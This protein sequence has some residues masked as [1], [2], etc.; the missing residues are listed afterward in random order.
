MAEVRTGRMVDTARRRQRHH[1][2]REHKKTSPGRNNY[3]K[4]ATRREPST[5][6]RH[7]LQ[8]HN[9]TSS[10][11]IGESPIPR[12]PVVLHSAPIERVILQ[13]D[14]SKIQLDRVG[15]RVMVRVEATTSNSI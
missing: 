8:T 7:H 11:S 1:D 9:P 5:D 12:S 15:Q 2:T 10:S 4:P 13:A 6:R 14:T 3:Q